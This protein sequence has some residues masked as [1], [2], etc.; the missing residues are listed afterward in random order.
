[1]CEW[2]KSFPKRTTNMPDSQLKKIPQFFRRS[3]PDSGGWSAI[4]PRDREWEEAYR[5]RWQHDKVVRSTHGVNCTGSC[6][7]KIYVKDGIIT[8]ETQQ[9]DYPTN[10]PDLP[11]YE[12]RGCP[13]GASFSWYIYSPLRVKYPYIR[14]ALWRVWQE[15]LASTHGDPVEAWQSIVEDPAKTARYKSARGKGGFVRA[16]NEDLYRLISASLIYTIRKY[17]P[18]RIFGF[19]PI[20]AMSMVSYAAGTRFLSL[21]GGSPIS[22]YDWYSDLPTSSPEI[23]GEQTDVPES[24]DWYNSTYLLMWGSNLPMTRTPDAH[25]MV[26]ARYKGTKVVAI[27]PDYTDNVKFGDI[28][29]PVKPGTDGALGIA[30]THV[31]LKEFYVDRKVEYFQKYVSTYTDLPFLLTLKK[32]GKGYVSDNFLVASDLGIDTHNAE[33]KGIVWDDSSKRLA[34]PNGSIGFRWGE[35]G[36]WNLE[37]VE[38]ERE[39]SPALTLLGRE[40]AVVSV[41]LPHF[42]DNGVKRVLH[43]SVPAKTVK[44]AGG[45]STSPPC[46]TCFWRRSGW[47]GLFPEITPRTTM[48]RRP[49]HQPGRSR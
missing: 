8:W 23:W 42:E 40:D 35:D 2:E 24:A 32:E 48:T 49:A 20:P 33:W 7:W 43:R 22:F 1:M 36:K 16:K 14:G 25:F 10:G 38:D 21:I 37:M 18:D 30:M 44:T 29:V 31:I 5:S 47:A 3:Q 45:M 12:P 6:S 11:E 9:T 46:S 13:R 19:T 15:A 27:S 28:W 34:V 26:E 41:D 39:I 17:G 4:V